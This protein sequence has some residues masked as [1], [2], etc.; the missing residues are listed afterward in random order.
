MIVKYSDF[1]QEK[2]NSEVLCEISKILNFSNFKKFV[3]IIT[4]G[5]NKPK[6]GDF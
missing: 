3:E 4:K 1:F 5:H 6:A 2:Q